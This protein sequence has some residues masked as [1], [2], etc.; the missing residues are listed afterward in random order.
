MELLSATYLDL[1]ANPQLSEPQ[2][3]PHQGLSAVQQLC[4]GAQHCRLL[5][6]KGHGPGMVRAWPRVKMCG[7]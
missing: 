6:W 7:S 3:L 5:M 2:H 4:R 1:A